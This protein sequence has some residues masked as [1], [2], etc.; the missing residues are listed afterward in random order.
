MQT[1]FYNNHKLHTIHLFDSWGASVQV[2][3]C[4]AVR[5]GT[6]SQNASKCLSLALICFF[7]NTISFSQMLCVIVC[8]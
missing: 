8:F 4:L 3:V 2:Y 1:H 7:L 5:F 6:A